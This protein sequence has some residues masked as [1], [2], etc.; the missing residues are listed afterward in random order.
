MQIG[1]EGVGGWDE[2]P[3]VRTTSM[4]KS[5][6]QSYRS[7]SPIWELRHADKISA[8]QTQKLDEVSSD[9]KK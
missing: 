7:W 3:S 1:V 5:A 8:F 2:R 6:F 4:K 9:S